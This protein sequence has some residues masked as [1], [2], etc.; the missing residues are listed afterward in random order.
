[1]RASI[2][3]VS[4]CVRMVPV[5]TSNSGAPWCLLF[6]ADAS[7][8]AC[9]AAA[10]RAPLRAKVISFHSFGYMFVAT[11]SKNQARH[12]PLLSHDALS[13]PVT[14]HMMLAEASMLNAYILSPRSSSA[15]ACLRPCDAVRCHHGG[16][17]AAAAAVARLPHGAQLMTEAS[18]EERASAVRARSTLSAAAGRML[19]S[20]CPLM[21][22][23]AVGG[24]T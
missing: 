12:P 23:A 15:D 8:G 9:A 7:E 22:S 16:R 24:S 1:M 4:P 17:S 5:T 2:R 11:T 20:F 14:R 21:L 10:S 18:S 13:P 6:A 3:R 19:A